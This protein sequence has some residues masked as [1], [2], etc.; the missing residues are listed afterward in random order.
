MSNGGNV[1]FETFILQAFLFFYM[2]KL[3]SI[4]PSLFSTISRLFII[5]K[6]SSTNYRYKA[7]S[8]MQNPLDIPTY[9]VGNE[10]YRRNCPL[11]MAKTTSHYATMTK[12]EMEEYEGI[13]AGAVPMEIEDQQKQQPQQYYNN[14]GEIEEAKEEGLGF[15]F[16]SLPF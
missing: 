3:R 14:R 5:S 13:E 15:Y 16:P 10:I 1:E 9:R 6:F 7:V 12:N 4:S 2:Q 11:E 8:N